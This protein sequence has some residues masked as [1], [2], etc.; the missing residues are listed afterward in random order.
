M[1]DWND[2]QYL[3]ALKEG[4]TMKR[5]AEL[6][7]TN[8]TTVSRHIKRLSKKHGQMLFSQYKGEGWRMTTA[9]RKLAE[10]AEEFARKM[11]EFSSAAPGESEEV[12]TITSLDFLTT[13]YLAPR[14]HELTRLHP[15]ISLI[16]AGSDKRLSLAF[17]EAD[18]ALRFGR[19]MEGQLVAHK[20]ADVQFRLWQ[21]AV[22]EAHEWVG[23]TDDRDWTPDMVL[24]F[25]E[26]GKPPILRVSSY[27]AARRAAA[28]MGYATVGP[29]A[30]MARCPEL[31][32]WTEAEGVTREV[33]SVIH[34]SRRLDQT[35]AAV[36]NWTDSVFGR[37][38][39]TNVSDVQAASQVCPETH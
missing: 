30:V 26:F 6:L 9:G 1:R 25:T 39:Y 38:D 35:L 29:D 3:L 27:A 4:G 21:P 15:N 37:R 18:I 12:V 2:L 17:R 8:P 20:V 23:M 5:A 32:A 34:E 14:V 10:M 36:R 16:L 7:E 11:D 13:Y 24:G 19:P 33:W 22:G 28:T 31:R